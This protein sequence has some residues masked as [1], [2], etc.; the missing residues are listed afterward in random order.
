MTRTVSAFAPAGNCVTVALAVVNTQA[1]TVQFD[2]LLPNN[3]QPNGGN[4]PV[5]SRNVRVVNAGSFGAFI[6]LVGGQGGQGAVKGAGM[7][8]SSGAED[9]F[10]T[11]GA[12]FI[13][14]IGDGGPTTLYATPG[15]GV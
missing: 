6:E 5:K 1:N 14:A 15:E 3:I 2:G 4:T 12:T 7:Y 8:L 11:S 10:S 13:S 9:I